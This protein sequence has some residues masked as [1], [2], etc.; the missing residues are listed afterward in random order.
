MHG[1][2]ITFT[3]EPDDLER[4]YDAMFADIPLDKIQL[5][6]CMRTSDGLIVVDTCPTRDDFEAFYG[7]GAFRAM[8]ERHG[9]PEPS[10]L[11]DFPVHAA[12]ADGAKVPA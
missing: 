11:R 10:S 2:I 4:R 9:L 8:L 7:G 1:T 5:H 6:V 12:L 3:G